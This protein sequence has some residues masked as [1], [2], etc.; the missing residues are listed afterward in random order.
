[1]WLPSEAHNFEMR[2]P[3]QCLKKFMKYINSETRLRESLKSFGKTN[4]AQTKTKENGQNLQVLK[5][6]LV[7]SKKNLWAVSFQNYVHHY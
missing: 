4:F 5:A 3:Q 6:F 7:K 1:M 2:Q